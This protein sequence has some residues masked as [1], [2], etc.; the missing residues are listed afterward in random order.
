[1]LPAATKNARIMVF[2]YDSNWYGD[3]AVKVRLDNV[4]DDL[5]RQIERERQV[6]W[7][8]WLCLLRRRLTVSRIAQTAH[9]SLLVIVLVA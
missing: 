1:M 5:R 9:W 3:D 7:P 2:N 6:H 4:A 8:V